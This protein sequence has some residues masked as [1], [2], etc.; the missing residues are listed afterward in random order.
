LCYEVF[1]DVPRP[2]LDKTRHKSG[3]HADSIVGSA[4]A[5]PTDPLSNQLQQFSIQ[6]T[7]ASPTPSSAAPPAQTSDVHS[8]QSMNPKANQQS[9]GKKKKAKEG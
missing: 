4:Q 3:P 5:K 7:M 6:Q 9:E 8:V 1:P 2:I